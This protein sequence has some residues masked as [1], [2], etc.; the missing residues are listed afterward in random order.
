MTN[1]Y[2]NIHYTVPDPVNNINNQY[3]ITVK[4][5]EINFI[6]DNGTPNV[7]I[8]VFKYRNNTIYK[9]I[10]G[11]MTAVS[12]IEL[13]HLGL[14]P[15]KSNYFTLSPNDMSSLCEVTFRHKTYKIPD[16]SVFLVTPKNV[17]TYECKDMK[18]TIIS[19]DEFEDIVDKLIID[20]EGKPCILPCIDEVTAK[21][22][23]LKEDQDNFY[24]VARGSLKVDKLSIKY[25]EKI[26]EQ[27]VNRRPKISIYALLVFEFLD[28]FTDENI[29]I[30]NSVNLENA[31]E[32]KDFYQ[33]LLIK[34][35]KWI[36]TLD[37]IYQF[38]YDYYHTSCKSE[39]KTFEFYFGINEQFKILKSIHGEA[40]AIQ[41]MNIKNITEE[42][43]IIKKDS[44]DLVKVPLKQYNITPIK[45]NPEPLKEIEEEIP[46]KPIKEIEEEIPLKPINNL[47][48]I[49]E[50]P[51][52][53]NQ[54]EE[55]L[56]LF[57]FKTNVVKQVSLESVQRS[58]LPATTT[59]NGGDNKF[60]NKS[61]RNK[62]N[63]THLNECRN[64]GHK[65]KYNPSHNASSRNHYDNLTT[66][67]K[68]STSQSRGRSEKY[69]AHCAEKY[70]KIRPLN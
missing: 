3:K 17:K 22:A 53:I 9:Y 56:P 47:E 39:E 43:G 25:Y 55:N 68:E 15:I 46:L 59:S 29:K 13:K 61:N 23:E 37:D 58:N 49:K 12:F 41:I 11:V 69:S 48:E 30:L 28:L 67:Q 42:S 65:N 66:L 14:D 8:Q 6:D 32:E 60:V 4:A 50:I 7:R 16:N 54:K 5:E 24:R 20:V 19:G 2:V 57:T 44:D 45:L 35:E 10:A 64:N 62:S 40:A 31:C 63:G 34:E 21:I 52:E 51:H 26:K 70:S 18:L 1:N 27:F 38:I 36:E 33:L